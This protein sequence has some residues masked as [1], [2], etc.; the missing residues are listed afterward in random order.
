MVQKGNEM[1]S[2]HTTDK[3][4]YKVRWRDPDGK[5]RSKTFNRKRKAQKHKEEVE[6]EKA[7]GRR[8]KAPDRDPTPTIEEACEAFLLDRK[9][10]MAIGTPRCAPISRP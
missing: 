1:A 2:I 9:A 10:D 3:R 5:A 6:D 7:R 4:K 8:W